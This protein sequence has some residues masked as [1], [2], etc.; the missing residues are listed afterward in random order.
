[1]FSQV[2]FW[3]LCQTKLQLNISSAPY[4]MCYCSS[5]LLLFQFFFFIY[6]W[7]GNDSLSQ[8]PVIGPKV[9]TSNKSV[10]TLQMNR[11]M[12]QF[13]ADQDNLF[14]SDWILVLWSRPHSKAP[15]TPVIL[16][17]TKL[18]SL[19]VQTKQQR[20]ESSV[21][22]ASGSYTIYGELSR[23]HGGGRNVAKQWRVMEGVWILKKEKSINIE[24]FRTMSVLSVEGKVLLSTF[25]WCVKL[26]LLR[27]SYINNSV[28]KRGSL[29]HVWVHW[30]HRS[31]HT[32]D[33]AGAGK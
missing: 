33:L 23:W 28:Q 27:H 3:C 10:F 15:F 2:D 21:R 25:A 18:K 24:Q 31:C 12:L 19:K 20:C 30:T 5:I 22:G 11:T 26:F 7:I 14:W 32:A 8:F 4:P 13:D 16:V 17:Q 6:Y 29:K 9:Q 1:M